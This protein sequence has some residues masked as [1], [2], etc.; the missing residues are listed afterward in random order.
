MRHPAGIGSSPGEHPG[1][2]RSHCR[3]AHAPA[4]GR[5]PRRQPRELGRAGRRRTPPRPDYAVARFA[6]DPPFLSEVVR[7]DLPRL[8]D[9][10]GLD[11]VHLQCHIGTDTVSLA[12]LGARDDRPRLL[13]AGARAGAGA[14]PTAVG[15][16]VD[17]RRVRGLRRA[18]GARAG[19]FDLVYTGIGALCWLPDIRRWA[20]GR[21][22]AAAARRPAVHPRGP[23]GAVGARRPAARRPAR[24]RLPVL[25]AGPSRRSGTRAART[26]R[27]I[28]S[29]TQN[30]HARVEPRPRRDRHGPAR[31]RPGA[32]GARGARPRA[33]GRAARSDDARSAA[34]SAGSPTGPSGCRTATRCRRASARRG[35]QP[36]VRRGL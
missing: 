26:S 18:R 33:V 32:D 12:R 5:L 30:R 19:A 29:F 25:R 1:L 23:P 20:R 27:P 6:D 22:R 11:A 34:A 36:D 24:A 14:S 21:R 16:D 10:A 35:G 8:G 2:L 7:F 9:I 3:S 4:R 31:R 15:V 17:V 28:T 13:G